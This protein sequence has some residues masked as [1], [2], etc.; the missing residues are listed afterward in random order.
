MRDLH[1]TMNGRIEDIKV[2]PIGSQISTIPDDSFKSS[3]YNNND[4][5]SARRQL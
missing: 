4:D 1:A 2:I 5:R 3:F